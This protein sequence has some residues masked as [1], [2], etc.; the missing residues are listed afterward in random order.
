MRRPPGRVVRWGAVWVECTCILS[1]PLAA[2]THVGRDGEDMGTE[3][4]TS[5]PT[6]CWQGTY[7][8]WVTAVWI[9]GAQVPTGH[10]WHNDA[11]GA[12]QLVEIWIWQAGRDETRQDQG[13]WGQLWLRLHPRWVRRPPSHVHQLFSTLL[14]Q[15]SFIW[16]RSPPQGSPPWSP[17]LKQPSP[18]CFFPTAHMASWHTLPGLS[19]TQA[20]LK[21]EQPCAFSL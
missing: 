9:I 17:I 19:L 2:G 18:T 7:I 4:S 16:F 10:K 14:H 13:V 11:G 3:D 12:I 8:Q 20:C 21:Q 6:H 15:K 5:H 1:R